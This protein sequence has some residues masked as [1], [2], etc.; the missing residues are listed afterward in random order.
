MFGRVGSNNKI[1][2]V[3]IMKIQTAHFTQSCSPRPYPHQQTSFLLRN[4]NIRL[5][6]NINLL[7][8]IFL[9][10]STWNITTIIHFHQ[11]QPFTIPTHFKQLTSEH[12]GTRSTSHE[13]HIRAG[14]KVVET[15]T[16]A[17]SQSKHESCH[18]RIGLK[19]DNHVKIT[20]NSKKS[21][22]KSFNH[23]L[24]PLSW[25]QAS[26]KVFSLNTPSRATTREPMLALGT[27]DQT[28]Y[29]ISFYL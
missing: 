21:Q 12:S 15:K 24:T 7:L 10:Q 9:L 28:K 14:G 8:D 1:I 13:L 6:A 29:Y 18:A 4:S 20:K 22:I 17:K 19:F 3:V 25:N 27:L 5:L 2:T 11:T 16:G 26:L 23:S